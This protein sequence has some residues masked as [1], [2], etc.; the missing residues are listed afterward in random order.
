MPEISEKK[1]SKSIRIVR[2]KRE[3]PRSHKSVEAKSSPSRSPDTLF[4]EKIISPQQRSRVRVKKKSASDPIERG[5]SDLTKNTHEESFKHTTEEAAIKHTAFVNDSIEG[6]FAKAFNYLIP[7]Q[8]PAKSTALDALLTRLIEKHSMKYQFVGLTELLETVEKSKGN[9]MLADLDLDAL[10]G[11]FHNCGNKE[12]NKRFLCF[13]LT[14][15]VFLNK[16]KDC[17]NLL[18][19]HDSSTQK[20]MLGTLLRKLKKHE[21]LEHIKHGSLLEEL[22]HENIANLFRVHGSEAQQKDHGELRSVIFM[23]CIGGPRP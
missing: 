7:L 6:R 19:Q 15:L 10:S 5:A 22:N 18:Q 21:P 16:V 3:T 1:K 23:A 2:R 13:H 12:Q 20:M 4:A 17:E 9:F 8:L 11:L 14:A